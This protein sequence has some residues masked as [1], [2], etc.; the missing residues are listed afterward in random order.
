MSKK[1]ES[2]HYHQRAFEETLSQIPTGLGRRNT[3]LLPKLAYH[4]VRLGVSANDYA[5]AVV[6]ASSAC[7]PLKPQEIERAY[8]TASE[9]FGKGSAYS[10][11]FRR[12]AMVDP[13]FPDYVPSLIVKGGGS[14]QRADL[15][16]LSPLDLSEHGAGDK[17][18]TRAFLRALWREDEYLYLFQISDP[19]SGVLGV[20]LLS[21][22][23]WLKRLEE[24]GI[25]ADGL[26][27]N[28]F[29]GQA[30]QKRGGGESYITKECLA[31]F[32]YALIEFDR[33]PLDQQAALWRGFILK[34]KYAPRLAS[35]TYS[36]GKSIHALFY[37]G[38]KTEIEQSCW[39]RRLAGLFASSTNECLKADKA[40]FSPRQGTRL[41]GT[42]RDLNGK[43][44]ELLYLNTN[45]RGEV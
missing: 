17:A 41:A 29:T 38:A 34:S 28:P 5:M 1:I 45:A 43:I 13:G 19:R 24:V 22:N 15:R 10:M 8:R 23:D 42:E 27:P 30:K 20:N 2:I 33:L 6:D 36:G 35:L 16:A 44:Q 32:P 9:K 40:G 4:A 25:I 37:I 31:A 12:R 26:V 7:D 11:D 3:Y 21:R 18:Q 39:R 14:A